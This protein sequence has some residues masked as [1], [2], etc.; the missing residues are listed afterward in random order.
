MYG[1]TVVDT[2]SRLTDCEPIK[3]KKSLT[4]LNAIKKIYDRGIIKIPEISL[5]VDSGSEFKGVFAKYFK[6][7]NINI[8]IAQTGRSRQQGLVESR[9]GSIASILLK[10]MVAEEL[11][12][13][14]KSIEW[15]YYLPKLITLINKHF[16]QKEIILT[17]KQILADVKTDG[18][19]E[20]L[21]RGTSVRVQLDKPVN[22]NNQCLGS[23]RRPA[24]YA[25]DRP[26]GAVDSPPLPAAPRIRPSEFC[27][28]KI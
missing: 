28:N 11:L 18:P 10:R 6:D 23:R 4:V 14:E 22:I 1:L 12:T 7:K 5:E 2:G 17:P 13:K 20:L 25:V 9:N 26:P 19:T 21:Q 8:R 15:V 24:F 16:Y 3:D 27:K